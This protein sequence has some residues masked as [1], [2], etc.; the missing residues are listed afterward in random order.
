MKAPAVA[1]DDS[2]SRAREDGGFATKRSERPRGL[3]ALRGWWRRADVPAVLLFAAAYVL[4]YRFGMAFSASSAAPFWPPDAVLLTA[5]LLSP[6]S[7]WWI[8]VGVA[9]PIRLFTAVP[10]GTPFAFLLAVYAVDSAKGVL[11]AAVLR[12]VLSEPP[13]ITTVRAFAVFGLVA[14]LLVPALGAVAGAAARNTLG[15]PFGASWQQW[16]MGNAMTQLVLT[17]ALLEMCAAVR[18]PWR[19]MDVRRWVEAVLLVLGLVLTGAMA[20]NQGHEGAL[21]T[22]RQL[23]APVPLLF[24]AA[25]RFGM[26]GA[27]AGVLIVV[28]LSMK[29]ALERGG[30]FVGQE[31]DVIALAIQQYWFLTAAP[32]YLVAVLVEQEAEVKRSLVESEA[33]FR[34]MADTTPAMIWMSGADGRRTWFNRHWLAF[35]GR[36]PDT[37]MGEGW[38]DHVHPEDREH[39]VLGYRGARDSRKPL[40]IEY[41]LSSE[42]GHYHWVL[43]QSVPRTAPDQGVVGYIGLCIDITDR[44]RAESEAHAHRMELARAGRVSTMGQLASAMAH[45]LNQ[46]L[47]AILRNA[48]AAELILQQEPL[49]LQEVR[50]IL[51][52][53]RRDDQRAGAVIDRMR[54]MLKRRDLEF[55]PLTVRQLIDQITVLLRNEMLARRVTL[56]LDIPSWVPRVRGDRVH[57]QQVLINLLVNGADA[58]DGAG[59]EPRRLDVQARLADE[60]TVT[61]AVRDTG[62]GIREDDLSRLFEPFF[63]TKPSGMGM[64]LAISKTIVESHG[65]RIWAEN[66]AEGGATVSFTLKVADSRGDT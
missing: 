15:H 65:G 21:V 44:K 46:P 48:E 34:N 59:Y 12:R 50:A 43:D 16:F 2:R 11:A 57:L 56:Q 40:T 33:R 41:R 4:A 8:L 32:L 64:G 7:R 61:V 51:S 58:M 23:Y 55:E 35:T 31:H 38:V 52:D 62:P 47:G 24:W 25:I 14:V 3:D 54:A 36:R 37:E 22:G 26:P 19:A 9:L 49:D 29:A 45:E 66:N 17:P 1:Y 13:R 39:V 53:I 60:Q 30:A 28:S 10:A 5:L 6:P 42:D 18:R 27:S 20:F 63:T